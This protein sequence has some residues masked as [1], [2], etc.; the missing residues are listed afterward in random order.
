MV[1]SYQ[2][3]LH[4][5]CSHRNW[6]RTSAEQVIAVAALAIMILPIALTALV[7]KCTLGSPVLFRQQRV[8]MG[9]QNFMILKFRTMRDTRD[10]E[11]KLLPDRQRE[12][13]FSRFLRKIRVDEF[14]QLLAI[15]DGKMSFVG[16]RPLLPETIRFMG[17]LGMMRCRIRPGLTGWAQVNGN[18]KLSDSQKLSLD[19]WYI[20]NCSLALDMSILFKT[21]LTL[22][23][24][25][26]VDQRNLA[27]ASQYVKLH[28][29]S[30]KYPEASPEP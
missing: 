19:I 14:P 29:G 15:A 20:D 7:T 6:F 28:Y 21:L 3:K 2:S 8:G 17:Q 25:E 13:S 11:G 22:L 27:E 18:T 24:G 12:T 4:V 1:H 26:R 10:S 16:P 30:L 9:M 5:I 23:L